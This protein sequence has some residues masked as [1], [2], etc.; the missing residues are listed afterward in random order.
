MCPSPQL[1]EIQSHRI[2]VE[3]PNF[4]QLARTKTIFKTGPETGG[5]GAERHCLEPPD[6]KCLINSPRGLGQVGRIHV[7]RCHFWPSMNEHSFCLQL[8]LAPGAYLV[9]GLPSCSS[10]SCHA[11]PCPAAQHS[12]CLLPATPCLRPSLVSSELCLPA[13]LPHPPILPGDPLVST[14]RCPS[15]SHWCPLGQGLDPT[16]LHRLLNTRPLPA[17]HPPFSLSSWEASAPARA[18]KEQ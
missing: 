3:S 11:L 6:P 10:E 4:R 12:P 1:E 15:L 17:T 9:L 2:F 14:C 7:T 8:V 16:P 18:E 5:L 13:S